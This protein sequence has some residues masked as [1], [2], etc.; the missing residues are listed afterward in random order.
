MRE[1]IDGVDYDAPTA[2]ATRGLPGAGK[3]TWAREQAE[4]TGGVCLN[5]DG[6]RAMLYGGWSDDPAREQVITAVQT[7]VLAV[8]LHR[9]IDVFVDDLNLEA[10]HIDQLR[11]VA[12][13][14]SAGFNVVD[15]TDVDVEVCIARDAERD[16]ATRLGADKIRAMAGRLLANGQA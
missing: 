2:T 16:D 8:L 7:A 14:A 5:R 15:F 9:G 11:W 6:L 13:S 4:V 12:A 1:P 10:A 3:S